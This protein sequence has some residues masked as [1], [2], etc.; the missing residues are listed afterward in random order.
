[1]RVTKLWGAWIAYTGKTHIYLK[2]V[3]DQYGLT[4]RIG[5]PIS[6]HRDVRCTVI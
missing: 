1:M 4:V 6:I 5:A 2:A 3:H